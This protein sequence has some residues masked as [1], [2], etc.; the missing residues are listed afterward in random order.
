MQQKKKLASGWLHQ[1]VAHIVNKYC[2]IICCIGGVGKYI[3]FSDGGFSDKVVC[4]IVIL[5]VMKREIWLKVLCSVVT[6]FE[7]L[8]VRRLSYLKRFL[9][10]LSPSRQIIGRR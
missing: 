4:V 10:F 5:R 2:L 6:R 3:G 9:L 7:A 1:K 8:S